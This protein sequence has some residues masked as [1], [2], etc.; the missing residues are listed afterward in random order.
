MVMRHRFC[1]ILLLLFLSVAYD[2]AAQDGLPPLQFK[3]IYEFTFSNVAFGRIGIDIIQT[4][5]QYSIAS[6]IMTM[7][8]INFFVK[9]S[10]H[11]TVSAK[12][13]DF[14]YPERAYE[15]HYKTR[16]KPR[17]VKLVYSN[18]HV[19]DEQIQ[20][21]ENRSKRPAVAAAVKD[22]AFD[23]LSF[24]IQMRQQLYY[25]LQQKK[26]TYSIDVYDGRRVTQADFTVEGHRF[27]QFRN[28]KTGVVVVAVRRKL[29]AG[30][31]PDEMND[32]S[33]NEPP[34]YIYFTDDTRLVPIQ[35]DVNLWMGMLSAT[36]VKEC[37]NES[38]LFGQKN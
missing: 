16:N 12:G 34:L 25:A 31:S 37:G 7:G 26:P 17:Y 20:P 33:R 19:S 18:N 30:F 23:P 9:H 14:L 2:S 27:I 38:C 36:L 5:D 21:P 4:P 22:N 28:K 10:S 24:V 35:F 15:T 6:D 1:N 29:I 13:K 32:I 3:G 8:L 11:T